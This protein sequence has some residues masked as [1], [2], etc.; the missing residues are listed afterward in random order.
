M[1]VEYDTVGALIRL[2][3]FTLSL[4]VYIG[5]PHFLYLSSLQF[6]PRIWKSFTGNLIYWDAILVHGV[7]RVSDRKEGID[8]LATDCL[9][10]GYCILFTQ[11]PRQGLG[12][13]SYDV[14]R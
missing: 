2:T 5:Q 12:L 6:S 10:V 7:H 14:G 3:G 9:N 4:V 13:V 8:N 11:V 1:G